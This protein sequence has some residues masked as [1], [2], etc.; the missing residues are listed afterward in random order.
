MKKTH[1]T[2]ALFLAI[3]CAV[4][5]TGHAAGD[6]V[7]GEKKANACKGCHGVAGYT[8]AYPNYHVPKVGGQHAQY[9]I[10][11][12]KEYQA[13]KREHPTMTANASTLDAQDIEDIAAYFESVGKSE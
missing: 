3:C 2:S 1:L 4:S 10:T 9:L 13:G 12:L 11:A 7:A 8:N 5:L 6:P